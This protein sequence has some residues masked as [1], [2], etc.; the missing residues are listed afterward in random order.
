MEYEHYGD[1]VTRCLGKV[2]KFEYLSTRLKNKKFNLACILTEL[3]SLSK[4]DLK[5]W[6]EVFKKKAERKSERKINNKGKDKKI[7]KDKN[8]RR[9]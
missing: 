6:D 4:E 7:L 5:Q 3:K 2:G 1:R 9:K 8:V